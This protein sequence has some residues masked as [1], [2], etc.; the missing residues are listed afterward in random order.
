MTDAVSSLAA[1]FLK[2]GVQKGDV[3]FLTSPNCAEYGIIYLATVL[4]GAIITTNNPIY[5]SSKLTPLMLLPN[6]PPIF[7]FF[8]DTPD[9]TYLDL[10]LNLTGIRYS[11]SRKSITSCHYDFPTDFLIVKGWGDFL[12]DNPLSSVSSSGSRSSNGGGRMASTTLSPDN[13]VLSADILL[14]PCICRRDSPCS[15][16]EWLQGDDFVTGVPSSCAAG[17]PILEG[18]QPCQGG[19]LAHCSIYDSQQLT[20]EWRM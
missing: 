14:W 7:L 15:E 2:L 20:L 19:T 16:V 9:F 13:S 1:N 11:S 3:V 4:I 18:W 10:R 6:P 5:T 8:L 12:D 17:S